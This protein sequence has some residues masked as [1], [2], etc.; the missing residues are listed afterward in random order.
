MP[1]RGNGENVESLPDIN[2]PRVPG[3]TNH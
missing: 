3:G 2:P 1:Q